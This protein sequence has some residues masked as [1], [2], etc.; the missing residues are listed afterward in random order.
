MDSWM[1]NN[2]HNYILKKINDEGKVLISELANS[3]DVSE[4]TIRRDLKELE[5]V[6]L[7][8]R[9]Y[10]GA[11]SASGRS[12]EPPLL[13]RSRVEIEAKIRIGKYAADLVDDGDSLAIDIGS[14][15]GEFAR[16]LSS[17]KNLTIITPGLIIAD[18]FITKP[19]IRTILPGG[20]V[21]HSERSLTGQLTVKAF[22]GLFVDKLFLAMGGISSHAGCTEYNW[23]DSVVKH[24][25]IKS[26]KEVIALV[27]AS[28]FE[29]IAFAQ[30]CPL[31]SLN[32]LITNAAPPDELYQAL[33]EAH[34]EVDVA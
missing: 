12:Y 10:G 33:K 22:E 21:R 11:V 6:H 27:D 31:A 34:V 32:R 13:V 25:M 29:V 30:I 3:L 15:T 7:L 28:K 2:R 4:M 24:A 23:E 5:A 14:T 19:D 18:M 9:V 8:R 20:I 16:N 17:K 26:A 1:T